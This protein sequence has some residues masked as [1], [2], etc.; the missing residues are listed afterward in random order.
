MTYMPP[1]TAFLITTS[2]ITIILRSKL[3]NAVQDVPNERSL[4]SKPIPRTGGIALMA[5]VLSSWMLL[6]PFVVWWIVVPT[7]L[8][9]VISFMDDLYNLSVKQRLLAHM[10]AAAMLVIGASIYD[11]QGLWITISLLFAVVWMINLY[12]FMDG[13]DGLA[14]GMT[15]FGF[16]NY[17]I[18][19]LLAH[20]ESFAMMNLAISSAALGFLFF[21]FSP[22]KIFMGDAGSIPLGFL[23]AA[24]GLWGWQRGDWSPLFPV[25][26]FLPFIADATVTLAKRTLRGM[27][28]TEA[29]RD[30]YYQRAIQSG[31][32][33]RRVAYVEYVFMAAIGMSAQIGLQQGMMQSYLFVCVAFCL[34]AMVWLDVRWGKR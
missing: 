13:S 1:I 17:G 20:D 2:L 12:N 22:A 4:H 34:V 16:A 5:G 26:V 9:F 10:I 19:A 33:H 27:K 23:V 7:V 14:G 30:H 6:W 28:I 18:A 8:L 29:H 31:M 25:L 11:Q 32:S 3:G 15:L 21:N 24:M